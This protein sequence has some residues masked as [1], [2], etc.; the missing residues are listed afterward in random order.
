[1][2]CIKCGSEI[3]ATE[4]FQFSGRGMSS[5][6]GFFSAN[7][8]SFGEVTILAATLLAIISFFLPWIEVM[9]PSMEKIS[10]NG[11]STFTFSL[12]L[13]F[14]YSVWMSLEKKRTT[15]QEI[16]V[17]ASSL[18]K[19]TKN[20]SK[21]FAY[22]MWL[23]FIYPAWVVLNAF[24]G[25]KKELTWYEITGYL[26]LFL[27]IGFLVY[28]VSRTA[29]QLASKPDIQRAVRSSGGYTVRD[30]LF[31]HHDVAARIV[32]PDGVKRAT[33]KIFVNTVD[34]DELTKEAE[35]KIGRD[36]LNR[37]LRKAEQEAVREAER[38]AVLKFTVVGTGWYMFM[39]ACVILQFGIGLMCRPIK[40]ILLGLSAE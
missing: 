7:G 28:G 1:M 4:L 37:L 18:A 11:F 33:G 38:D 2:Y 3:H 17:M 20:E 6:S 36:E 25:K 16:E 14:F 19:T 15:F 24:F 32:G 39:C 12:G 21:L 34:V 5:L 23:T 8:I 31:I 27:G 13:I 9:I 35:Q 22:L 26:G 40:D 30:N 29:S 10:K